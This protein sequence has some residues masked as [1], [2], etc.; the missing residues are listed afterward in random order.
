[1]RMGL[2]TP[3]ILRS[4]GPLGTT[5][6]PHEITRRMFVLMDSRATTAAARLDRFWRNVRTHTVHDPVDFKVR[7]LGDWMLNRK[8]P[9][10]I[11]YS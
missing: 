1:M 5:R 11:F 4:P 2:V 9:K 6:A 7:E 3:I 10:P 8:I